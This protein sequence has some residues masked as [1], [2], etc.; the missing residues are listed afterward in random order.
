MK[1]STIERRL[2]QGIKKAGGL[3]LKFVSPGH[4]GVPDR[5]VLLPRG[6][7]IFVELKTEHGALTPLQIET[8]NQ[9]RA[10]GCEVRTLYGSD[11]VAGFLQEV[12][13]NAL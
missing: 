10:L 6:R 4:A 12:E 1:E 13:K 5:L 8:H 3:A 11:Y 2:V 9:L 7:V